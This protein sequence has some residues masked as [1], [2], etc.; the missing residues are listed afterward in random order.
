MRQELALPSEL[1]HNIVAHVVAAYV[2]E[3]LG[4][5]A[6]PAEDSDDEDD[7]CTEKRIPY[8]D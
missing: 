5:E 8:V 3:I 7:V 6:T 1:I 2:D 4:P